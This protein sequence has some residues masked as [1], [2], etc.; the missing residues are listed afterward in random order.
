L[1][2]RIFFVFAENVLCGAAAKITVVNPGLRYCHL[3]P[4]AQKIKILNSI[5]WLCF[6]AKFG[7]DSPAALLW[8]LRANDSLLDWV[9]GSAVLSAGFSCILPSFNIPHFNYFA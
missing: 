9:E 7:C 8:S 4:F 3:A 2:I 5:V 1:T 6:S